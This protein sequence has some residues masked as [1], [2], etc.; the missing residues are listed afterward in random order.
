M[1]TSTTYNRAF[2]NVMKG[3]KKVSPCSEEACNKK[4]T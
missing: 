1:A 2:W 4:G 3:K